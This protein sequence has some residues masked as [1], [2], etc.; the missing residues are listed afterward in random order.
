MTRGKGYWRDAD[1]S[2]VTREEAESAWCAA[3]HVVLAGVARSYHATIEY[4]HLA[5]EIQSQSGIRTSVP[6]RHWIGGVLGLVADLGQRSDQPPLTALVVQK[7]TGM[8]GV[9]YDYVLRIG[10][11]TPIDDPSEREDHAALA[12]LDCYRWA[13]V[14]EPRGGWKPALAPALQRA[15]E[16]RDRTSAPEKPSRSCPRCSLTLPLTGVCDECG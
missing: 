15:R 12:R 4:G 8:V 16:W 1:G 11:L 9:G 14:A 2:A 5:E 3:G 6:M 10:G 7:G 13:G